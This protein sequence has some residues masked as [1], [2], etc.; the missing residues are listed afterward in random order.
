MRH[1]ALL[2]IE[3][4]RRQLFSHLLPLPCPHVLMLGFLFAFLCPHLYW[5]EYFYVANVLKV[6]FIN[7]FDI[8]LVILFIIIKAA[9]G[10]LIAILTHMEFVSLLPS[11]QSSV[12]AVP[13]F[14]IIK[15]GRDIK[16][17]YFIFCFSMGIPVHKPI[18]QNR[19][20]EL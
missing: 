8:N 11:K 5:A 2:L 17:D 9:I 7:L 10:F 14:I 6:V 16:K 20:W 15:Q 1:S 12:N 13:H 18:P 3:K 19:K 4:G